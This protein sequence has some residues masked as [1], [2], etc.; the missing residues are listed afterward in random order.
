MGNCC[1]S[2]ERGAEKNYDLKG[3]R[4]LKGSKEGGSHAPHPD[5]TQQVEEMNPLNEKVKETVKKLPAFKENSKSNYS[6]L[7]TL[8]PYEYENKAT[9]IGQYNDGLRCG[10]GKQVWP[11]GSVYEGYWENDK[12]NGQGRLVHLE[13]DV[14]EGEWVDDKAHGQGT[15][16]H[17]DGTKYV[18][19]WEN[20]KQN[21]KG[22]ETWADGS[23]YEGDYKDSLKHGKG[24][25]V[26]ND[27]SRYDGEFRENDIEGYGKANTH[28]RNLQLG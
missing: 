14:Y 16:T 24:V 19:Q 11:D 5:F 12:S 21:G 13:G 23:T 6:D 28:F 22:K 9:Y 3:N 15:Y 7:P 10:F 25:F 27:K 17:T 26:W 20:D 18:G 2:D 1:A 8:G 4:I